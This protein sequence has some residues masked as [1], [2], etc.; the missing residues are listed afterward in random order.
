MSADQKASN[1]SRWASA[2][3]QMVGFLLVLAAVAGLFLLRIG[4]KE[5]PSSPSRP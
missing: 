2:H 1:L 4:R 3:Q 5:D